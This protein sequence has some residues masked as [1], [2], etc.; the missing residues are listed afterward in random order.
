MA[1]GLSFDNNGFQ[2][3]PGYKITFLTN[4]S[5]SVYSPDKKAFINFYV[6]ME[7]DSIFN[8]A[9][10]YFKMKH[11]NKDSLILQVLRG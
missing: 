3:E 8:V 11:M 7:G 5:A 9:R 10:S 2:T 4:D 6:F 1:N